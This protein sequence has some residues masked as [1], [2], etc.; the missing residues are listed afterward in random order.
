MRRRDFITIVGGAAATW[1]LEARAQQPERI[2]R[3]GVLTDTADNNPEGQAR[4]AALR[5]RLQELGWTEGHNIR[6]DYRW[7]GGDTE[8]ARAYAAEIVA[9]Q[10]DVIFALANAQLAPLARA[11]RTTP[12]VFV[13]V[14]DPVG[15]GYVAS[16]AHPG[17]NIT[18]FIL[19]EPSMAE[20]WVGFLKEIV[21]SVA[22]MAFMVNPDT[23]VRRGTFYIPAFESAAATLSIEAII[24]QVRSASDIEA[25][26]AALAQKPGSGLIVSPDSFTQAHDELIVRITTH[27]RLPALYGNRSFVLA[28][29]LMSYGPNFVEIVR[30]SASYI[31]RILK[32][33][34]PADLPVQAPIKFELVI[35]L[36]AAKSLGIDVPPMLLARTD[37][38]IE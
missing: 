27:H 34:K 17:G 21:P 25:A 26:I 30:A 32:G 23:A 19:Y 35:N 24:A 15:P 11:T 37:E 18:G 36:K 14:S 31:D 5:K 2:R 38:V 16:F 29:G 10:P 28:G 22:R 9:L 33:E 6:V 7:A 20:K 4:I 3:I 12:I 13:G 1:P 8:R